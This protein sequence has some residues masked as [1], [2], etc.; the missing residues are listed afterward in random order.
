M[1]TKTEPVK[2]SNKLYCL[3]SVSLARN[4]LIDFITSESSDIL[5]NPHSIYIP[6]EFL[7]RKFSSSGLPVSLFLEI[8]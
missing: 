6:Q 7:Q 2:L 4:I 5:L 8:K 1:F 3:V